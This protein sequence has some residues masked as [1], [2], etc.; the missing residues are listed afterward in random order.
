MGK[1]ASYSMGDAHGGLIKVKK[2]KKKRKLPPAV[3]FEGEEL[4]PGVKETMIPLPKEDHRVNLENVQNVEAAILIDKWLE[5]QENNR[6]RVVGD[7]LDAPPRSFHFPAVE[8]PLAAT[9]VVEQPVE[10][11]EKS[12]ELVGGVKESCGVQNSNSKEPLNV[13]LEVHEVHGETVALNV[14]LGVD[15]LHG[16]S[17]GNNKG[18]VADYVEG[19]KKKK[20]NQKGQNSVKIGTPNLPKSG[21]QSGPQLSNSGQTGPKRATG[22]GGSSSGRDNGSSSGQHKAQKQVY[23][24]KNRNQRVGLGLGGVPVALNSNKERATSGGSKKSYASIFA[25]CRLESKGMKLRYIPPK[26]GRVVLEACD[27]VPFI[28]TW[29]FCMI[30]C[31]TGSFPG[32]KALDDIIAT[33][34]VKCKVFPY[35]KG[36]TVFKFQNEE[37][38]LKVYKGGPYMAF[39]K[40]LMLKMVEKDVALTDDLFTTIPVWCVFPEVPLLF[41]SE[42]GLSKITSKIG[43]PLHT[44]QFT[45]EKTRMNYARALI[46]ID[47]SNPPI[48]EFEVEKPD[49]SVYVQ[50]CDYENYPLFCHHCKVFGHNHLNC[51]KMKKVPQPN[52][53]V[54]KSNGK[55]LEVANQVA[56]MEDVGT[57]VLGAPPKHHKR[58][59]APQKVAKKVPQN[60]KK[61]GDNDTQEPM[62]I[63]SGKQKAIADDSLALMEGFTTGSSTPYVPYK[64]RYDLISPH[65]NENDEGDESGESDDG[66]QV[67]NG[68]RNKKSKRRGGAHESS[69]VSS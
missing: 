45:H 26:D 42:S 7:K 11:V 17:G 3:A 23:V 65:D 55:A 4:L 56:I 36:W 37:E 64:G 16:K 38:R 13:A 44:D 59:K 9:P 66:W 68:K 34:G 63:D 41:W 24:E 18:L 57:S 27:E 8:P 62:L 19:N 61:T 47:V 2:A 40:T 20:P 28:K 22:Q 10:T 30:G 52:A 49:G 32:R 69:L 14:P 39:G 54:N 58:P 6:N 29:G 53:I 25:G 33:W 31:F 67:H 51:P 15:T 5:S 60:S 1:T 50:T 35:G 48:T 46:E 21:P 12:G 43:E